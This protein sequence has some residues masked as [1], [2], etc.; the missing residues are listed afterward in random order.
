VLM[1][2]FVPIASYRH[3]QNQEVK[4]GSLSNRIE[5]GIPCNLTISFTYSSVNFGTESVMWNRIK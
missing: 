4:L 5:A 2:N 1:F 3:V